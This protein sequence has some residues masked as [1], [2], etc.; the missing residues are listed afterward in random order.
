[1]TLAG[2]RCASAPVVALAIASAMASGNVIA[3]DAPLTLGDC[4]RRALAQGFELELQ[5]HDLA[6]AREDVPIA[7]S[8]FNPVL[9]ADG[10]R[11]SDRTARDSDVAAG[12]R[13]SGL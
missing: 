8:V 11:N 2:R 10:G 3:Q 12:F 5:Q 1:M 9:S 13:S 6:I 4:V 7:Q